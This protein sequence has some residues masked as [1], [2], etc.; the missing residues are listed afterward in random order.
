MGGGHGEGNEMKQEMKREWAHSLTKEVSR[1]APP[2]SCLRTSDR[3]AAGIVCTSCRIVSL[4]LLRVLTLHRDR[5]V[6][7]RV[8]FRSSGGHKHSKQNFKCSGEVRDEE[9][10]RQWGR[11]RSS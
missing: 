7:E 8:I 2:C 9:E 3:Q 11:R 1:F 6:K 5:C 10:N 4:L